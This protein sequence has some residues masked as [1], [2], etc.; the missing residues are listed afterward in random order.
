MTAILL[1]CPGMS[2]L[3]LTPQVIK[4]TLPDNQ[5]LS[6]LT[7]VLLSKGILEEYKFLV[8]LPDKT[9]VVFLSDNFFT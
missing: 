6:Q 2:S 8:V 9:C 3:F 7:V 5:K 1:I 4:L